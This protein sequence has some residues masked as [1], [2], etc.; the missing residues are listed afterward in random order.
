MSRHVTL[1]L[2]TYQFHEV[3]FPISYNFVIWRGTITCWQALKTLD[4]VAQVNT[5]ASC[6]LAF[7]DK[8]GCFE[9]YFK[10]I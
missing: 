10:D 3:K 8:Q 9:H 2:N 6:A 4:T 1:P 7:S 5:D